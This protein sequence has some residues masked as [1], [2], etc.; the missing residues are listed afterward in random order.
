MN[1]F[2]K[3]PAAAPQMSEKPGSLPGDLPMGEKLLWQG[4]PNWRS[5]A[6]HAMHVRGIAIYFA[7]I[8]AWC[9]MS[10][11]TTAGNTPAAALISTARL[12]GF[13]AVPVALL[14]LYAWLTAWVT[15]Y[16][17]TTRRVVIRMGLAMPLSLNIPFSKVNGA[18]AKIRKDGTGDITLQL[19]E[20][21]KLGYVVLWP[22]V[23]PWRM[24]RPEPMLRA[25]PDAA[26]VAQFL[27]RGLAA[28]A[29]VPPIP[30]A[31]AP[32]AVVPSRNSVRA[33]ASPAAA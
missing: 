23:R 3:T 18:D 14:T 24:A 25:I 17:V 27:A 21:S 8:L 10:A 28:S 11:L 15:T 20:K 32:E 33:P 12:A 9:L 26:R 2:S 31:L 7:I 4:S 30:V 29:S 6:L 13:A 1:A 22:H 16:T 19:S 5:M